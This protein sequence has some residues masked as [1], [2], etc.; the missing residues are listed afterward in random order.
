MHASCWLYSILG[1]VLLKLCHQQ[2]IPLYHCGIMVSSMSVLDVKIAIAI[3]T[4]MCLKVRNIQQVIL[5]RAVWSMERLVCASKSPNL[6]T[7]VLYSKTKI[8]HLKQFQALYVWTGLS[9]LAS[10]GS[11]PSYNTVHVLVLTQPKYKTWFFFFFFFLLTCY[12][13]NI[14]LIL[15]NTF[16]L[17]LNQ[18]FV[19][20]LKPHCGKLQ[21]TYYC[22]KSWIHEW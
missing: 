19:D 21:F 3:N 15:E 6:S 2:V 16:F 7:V 22:R 8:I 13:N 17:I 10:L 20:P 11:Q 4:T 9:G 1:I 18:Y 14:W 5:R 12:A